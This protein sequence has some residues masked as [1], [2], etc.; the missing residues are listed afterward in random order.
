MKKYAWA[1]ITKSCTNSGNYLI[2]YNLNKLLK[3]K[4]FGEPSYIFDAFKQYDR[5][6]ASSV[7]NKINSSDYLIVPGCTTLSIKHYPGLSTI[8]DEVKTPIYNFGAAF[9]GKPQRHSLKYL[10]SYFQ[11]IGTR[12]PISHRFLVQNGFDSKFI[13]CPTLFSGNAQAFRDNKSNKILFILGLYKREAQVGIAKKLLSQGYK[14]TTLIQE[15]HQNEY[16]RKLDIKVLKY[17]PKTLLNELEQTRALVT[18]RLHGALPAIA[19]GVP[20][21]FIKPMEDTRF[22]LLEYLEI[23]GT[24][25]TDFET[26]DLFEF[27]ENPLINS[28]Q[29]T[30]ARIQELKKKFLDYIDYVKNDIEKNN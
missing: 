30:H 16:F 20:V 14:L 13:G 4:G 17:S 3:N 24:H 21:Y 8:V 5:P 22:S 27:L 26:D 9:F 10:N 29:Q 7:A 23:S 12:D 15:S 11:P 28:K 18:G 25:V 1:S 6:E 2:E 19:C